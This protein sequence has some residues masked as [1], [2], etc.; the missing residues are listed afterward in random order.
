MSHYF[1]DTRTLL[2]KT[3]NSVFYGYHM[4]NNS[5]PVFVS[6]SFRSVNGRYPRRDI[7]ILNPHYHVKVNTSIAK[8]FNDFPLSFHST[9]R[10][11]QISSFIKA[12]PL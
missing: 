2:F 5:V 9:S 8:L 6:N 12:T 11:I 4:F 10:L 3:L 7:I 1:A